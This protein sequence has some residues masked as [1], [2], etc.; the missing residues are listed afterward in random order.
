MYCTYSSSE[1]EKSR[2]R[3]GTFDLIH[4]LNEQSSL[5]GVDEEYTIAMGSDT[6]MDLTSFKWR[7]SKEVIQLVEGRF[8]VKPRINDDS[9]SE[10]DIWER[11]NSVNDQIKSENP[12]FQMNVQ[13]LTNAI[14]DTSSSAARESCDENFLA[15]FLDEMVLEYIKNNRLYKFADASV[16]Q[17]SPDNENENCDFHTT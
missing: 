15:T 12:S 3:L 14:S 10:S 6:F 5:K 13:L 16:I 4:Y 17:T 8:V 1:E 11:I 2:L 9:Y 7:N